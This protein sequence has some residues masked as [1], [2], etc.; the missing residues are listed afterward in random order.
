MSGLVN[1]MP[2]T[3]AVFGRP[4]F[5]VGTVPLQNALELEPLGDGQ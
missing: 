2:D 3:T 4:G 5:L 1:V